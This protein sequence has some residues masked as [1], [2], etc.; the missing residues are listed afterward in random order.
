MGR[1]VT[2][3]TAPA[4][5]K[6]TTIAGSKRLI[7]LLPHARGLWEWRGGGRL[8]GRVRVCASLALP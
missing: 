5:T 6:T 1:S 8:V 4:A 3:A 2:H 7:E